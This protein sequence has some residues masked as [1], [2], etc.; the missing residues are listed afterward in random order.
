[1]SNPNYPPLP[2]TV[3]KTANLSFP[4][5][6]AMTWHV[7]DEIRRHEDDEKILLLQRLRAL[8]D[9]SNEMFRFGY[10]IIG[11]KPKMKNRWVWGQ[12]APFISAS[13]FEAMIDEARKRNWIN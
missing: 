1:M 6:S 13:D 3:G 4:D 8:D 10:Y 12:F 11:K 9:P 7:I 2:S 5:G